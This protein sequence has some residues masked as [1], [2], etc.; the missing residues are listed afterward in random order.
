MVS[1]NV[2]DSDR[3]S[4]QETISLHLYDDIIASQSTTQ[5]HRPC[6]ILPRSV[7]PP[8]NSKNHHLKRIE[9]ADE[10]SDHNNSSLLQSPDYVISSI[11]SVVLNNIKECNA[12]SYDSP[13]ATPTYENMDPSSGFP[14]A[15]HRGEPIVRSDWTTRGMEQPERAILPLARIHVTEKTNPHTAAPVVESAEYEEPVVTLTRGQ[16]LQETSKKIRF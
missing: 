15:P 11:T 6:T 16:K 14:V 3:G 12:L 13:L 1:C 8:A 7:T 2:T 4:H 5:H 9:V 10:S